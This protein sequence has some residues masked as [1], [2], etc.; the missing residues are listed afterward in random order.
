MEIG[1]KKCDSQ[2]SVIG[3]NNQRE[4][5]DRSCAFSKRTSSE[6]DNLTTQILAKLED[7]KQKLRLHS[8]G[9]TGAVLSPSDQN[10]SSV[11]NVDK[12]GEEES[13]DGKFGVDRVIDFTLDTRRLKQISLLNKSSI[14][15]AW[16][17]KQA[18]S[19]KEKEREIK[20][21]LAR[22]NSKIRQSLLRKS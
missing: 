2:L 9:T 10:R 18:V 13:E 8:R 3:R 6:C 1:Q 5:K 4:E 17:G 20:E 19:P 16:T 22:S 12:S 15:G 11:Q 14:L 21:E 7:V